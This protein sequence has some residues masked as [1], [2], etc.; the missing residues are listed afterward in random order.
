MILTSKSIKRLITDGVDVFDKDGERIHKPL[1]ENVDPEQM[2]FMEG[3]R[4]DL[5]IKEIVVPDHSPA[6]LTPE[7]RVTPPTRP[8][9][10]TANPDGSEEWQIWYC[11]YYLVTTIEELNVPAYLLGRVKHRRT[12]QND[13]LLLLCCDVAPNF[14]GKLTFGLTE[15]RG[16]YT[17]LKHGTR[18]ATIT[19][20]QFEHGESDLYNGV[21]QGGRVSTDGKKER[22][23]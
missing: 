15:L 18:I 2:R 9:T 10:S 12:L 11:R 20:E 7:T 21:W 22:A 3:G 13:G 16:S 5:R 23:Y 6:I 14:Q 4:Y 19:F 8:A 17:T 1:I